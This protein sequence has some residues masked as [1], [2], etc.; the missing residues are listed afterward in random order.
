[1][2]FPLIDEHHD[3]ALASE[4]LIR[5]SVLG[6]EPAI[7]PTGDLCIGRGSEHPFRTK[8]AGLGPKNTASAE[9]DSTPV[10]HTACRRGDHS[11]RCRLNATH[12]S[13][14]K[15]E[16]RRRSALG[17]GI[18]E[19]WIVKPSTV[20]PGP[21]TTVIDPESVLTGA[22]SFSPEGVLESSTK[23]S[24]GAWS[25]VNATPVL[26]G[27]DLVVTLPITNNLMYFRLRP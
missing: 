23:L 8:H 4:G 2:T 6:L 20:S 1:M 10:G 25:A 14:A 18:W 19:K 7:E 13:A 3:R 16:P 11:W 24:A 17:S 22:K 26:N 12:A 5:H 15:P 9:G 27:N 21:S